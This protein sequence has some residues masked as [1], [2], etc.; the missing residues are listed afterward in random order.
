MARREC[1]TLA[2]PFGASLAAIYC[3]KRWASTATAE[4]LRWLLTPTT[5]L[6]ERL[7]AGHFVWVPGEGYLDAEARFRI[8][9]ACAGV[10]FL[11]AVLLTAAVRLAAAPLSLAVRCIASV[12]AVSLAWGMTVVVNALRITVAMALHRH[13]WWSPAFLAEPEAHQLIG[14]VVY[15]GA[16]T[17]LYATT[18]PRSEPQSAGWKALAVPLGCYAAITLGLPALNGALSNPEFARHVALVAGGAAAILA[19]GMGIQIS[20]PSRHREEEP[21]TEGVQALPAVPI[22]RHEELCGDS[23]AEPWGDMPLFSDPD[24]EP[25]TDVRVG[26]LDVAV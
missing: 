20:L 25:E 13:P 12:A 11:A 19:F 18:R 21:A 17:V 14:I 1:L 10:N 16:L 7:G 23:E 6:V 26:I 24:P 8:V 5:A 15:A 4:E 3:L 9:P 2:L 22:H